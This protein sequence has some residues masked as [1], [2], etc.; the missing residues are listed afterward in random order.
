MSA[1]ERSG[2]RDQALSL[3]HRD[4]GRDCPAID[5][6]FV[7]TEYDHADPVALIEYKERSAHVRAK[8]PNIRTL[9]NLASRANLPLFMAFYDN[10][11]WW[12]K[13]YPV[14]VAARELLPDPAIMSEREYVAFLYRVRHRTFRDAFAKVKLNDYKPEHFKADISTN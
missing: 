3:R 5:L 2:W 1:N 7:L 10:Q 9:Q 8:D 14:N 11:Q 6:D 4:W 12:F 13:V